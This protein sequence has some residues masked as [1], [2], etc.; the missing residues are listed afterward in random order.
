MSPKRLRALY[1]MLRHEPETGE[2]RGREFYDGQCQ[3]CDSPV[4]ETHTDACPLASLL[5]EIGGTEEESRQAALRARRDAAV[6][7]RLATHERHLRGVTTSNM[8]AMNLA[9][10]RAYGGF[11]E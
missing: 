2:N 6:R 10:K 11:G 7:E 1:L 3:S 8:D 9:F 4:Y 5:V